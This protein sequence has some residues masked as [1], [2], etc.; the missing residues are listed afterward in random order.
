MTAG[1]NKLNYRRADSPDNYLH[2]IHVMYIESLAVPLSSVIYPLPN[3][4]SC[5]CRR[6]TEGQL[7]RRTGGVGQLVSELQYLSTYLNYQHSQALE[8]PK[9]GLAGSRLQPLPQHTPQPRRGHRRFL[10][11]GWHG[12]NPDRSLVAR[13]VTYLGRESHT[14]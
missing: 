13:S 9:G 4:L 5:I 3:K 8:G 7:R 2:Y 11:F 1:Q 10:R 14:L 6:E 12:V